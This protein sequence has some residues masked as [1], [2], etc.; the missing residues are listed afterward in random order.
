[1]PFLIKYYCAIS[2]IVSSVQAINKVSTNEIIKELERSI[3]F[4]PKK[5]NTSAVEN[6][7]RH[8]F[9]GSCG[10]SRSDMSDHT[11]KSGTIML[12]NRKVV[13][14]RQ[15]FIKSKKNQKHAHMMLSAIEMTKDA[16]K[17][18]PNVVYSFNGGSAG[19]E[20]KTSK[21]IEIPEVVISKKFG[22]RTPGLYISFCFNKLSSLLNRRH[23]GN[24]FFN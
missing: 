5:T 13:V 15:S 10:K 9:E 1:M 12:L 6:Y 18:F 8:I 4:Y 23:N 19:N 3:S 17:Q 14:F 7:V 20:E 24:L 11:C 22:Y 21:N 2:L 16:A